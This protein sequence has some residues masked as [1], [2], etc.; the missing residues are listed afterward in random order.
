M[1]QDPILNIDTGN[2]GKWYLVFDDG[3][4]N[5]DTAYRYEAPGTW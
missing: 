2:C 4:T 5:D 3:I 1:V